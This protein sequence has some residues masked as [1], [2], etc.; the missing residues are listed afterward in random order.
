MNSNDST[1][2]YSLKGA[3]M[4][5]DTKG[6]SLQE[7]GVL[8]DANTRANA[9]HQFWIK[10]DTWADALGVSDRTLR[11]HV[12]SLIGKG[13]MYRQARYGRCNLYTVLPNGKNPASSGEQNPSSKG[14]NTSPS[15]G[16]KSSASNGK[17]TASLKTTS[18]KTTFIKID[19]SSGASKTRPANGKP[20]NTNNT[21]GKEKKDITARDAVR[22]YHSIV[23]G[24]GYE[25]E[26]SIPG[27]EFHF[28][29]KIIGDEDG[30]EFLDYAIRDAIDYL[31]SPEA[32]EFAPTSILM[33]I[34]LN[35]GTILKRWEKHQEALTPKAKP[36]PEQAK[37]MVYFNGVNIVDADGQLLT[38]AG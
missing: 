4:I 37:P 28:L 11:T 18:M 2:G 8:N 35:V 27:E 9:Q 15:N 38:G 32:A 16:K 17:P 24:L 14:K 25:S 7:R 26:G 20:K 36:K 13:L 6:L 34:K 23:R 22:W 10:I 33:L 1:N 21:L 30:P 5:R 3:Q 29:M 12:A 31:E 19:K